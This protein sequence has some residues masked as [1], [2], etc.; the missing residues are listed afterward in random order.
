MLTNPNKMVGKV[1][2]EHTTFP[3]QTERA[4]PALL[5]DNILSYLAGIPGLEPGT[6]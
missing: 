3:P 2:I 1:W 6:G 5:P 4:T